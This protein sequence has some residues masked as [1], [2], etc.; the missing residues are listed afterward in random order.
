MQNESVR[1]LRIYGMNLRKMYIEN[2]QIETNLLMDV[3]F[4][5]SH[6]TQNKTVSVCDGARI[7]YKLMGFTVYF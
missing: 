5:Y 6:N 2:A 3:S 7:K 4:V 1:I